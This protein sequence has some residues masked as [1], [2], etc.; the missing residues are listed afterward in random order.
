ME[1]CFS[2]VI[3]QINYTIKKTFGDTKEKDSNMQQ[4]IQKLYLSGGKEIFNN[5]LSKKKFKILQST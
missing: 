1:S 2:N 4:Q 5:F 3:G